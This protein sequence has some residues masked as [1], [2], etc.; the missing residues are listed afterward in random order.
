MDP[1]QLADLLRWVDQFAGASEQLR[2]QLSAA[3]IATYAGRN[4]YA[5]AE[6]AAAAQA[7]AAASNT[8]TAYAAGLASQYVAVTSSLIAGEALPAPTLVLPALRNGVPMET[9]YA[10]PAKLFRRLRAQSV[11]PA[12][13]FERS[14]AYA[15]QITHTNVLLAQR[16][17]YQQT[18][19]RLERA[20]GVTG[21][22]RVVH[23]EIAR[24]GSCGLCIVASDQVY[25]S[26]QLLPIH[27][28]CNCTILPIVG[29]L[30]PGSSLNNK[31]L[32]DFY[33]Q[34]GG[35]LSEQLKKTR[36]TVNNHG[37]YGPVL[38]YKGQKFTG[39]D[40]IQLAA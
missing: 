27:G 34:A 19:E 12:T 39:P 28:G 24:T 36:V 31:T 30:D 38:T 5:A 3:V 16:E 8:Q 25:H 13:A 4:F 35:N 18:L 22:R 23:P 32:T 29:A 20:A 15:T 9:V 17:A 33:T 40:D 1:Q 21:Y 2:N 7:A 10:R 37:E 11:D 26:S 6:V 14:M